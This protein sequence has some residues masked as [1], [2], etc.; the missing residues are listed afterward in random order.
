[1]ID[2]KLYAAGI[3]I[4]QELSVSGPNETAELVSV[5]TSQ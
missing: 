3:G 2:K 4:V 5:T 1:V